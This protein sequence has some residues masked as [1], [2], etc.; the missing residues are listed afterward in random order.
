MKFEKKDHK[1][2]VNGRRVVSVTECLPS[3]PPQL[4]YMAAFIAKTELG[5]K[6]HDEVDKLNVLIM[7]S[8]IPSSKALTKI[9][10]QCKEDRVRD[11]FSGYVEFVKQYKPKILASETALYHPRFGYAGTLDILMEVKSKRW[12]TDVKNTAKL[13]PYVA[14]Q[15][16][17]YIDLW[18]INNPSIP[19]HERSVIHLLGNGGFEWVRNYKVANLARDM[20]VFKAKLVST[21]WDVQNGVEK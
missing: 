10:E 13:E 9:A 20:N 11:Y 12:L 21:S 14:L 15:L 17:G 1:Y 7:R 5:R 4:K 3:P 2:Y 19:V 8:G 18:N 6:V 16:A